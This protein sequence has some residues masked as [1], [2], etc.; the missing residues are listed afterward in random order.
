MTIHRFTPP[1]V[2]HRL[3]PPPLP[4]SPPPFTPVNLLSH[5]HRRFNRWTTISDATPLRQN[6][7]SNDKR[8]ETYTCEEKFIQSDERLRPKNR[9][10]SVPPPGNKF[11]L[12]RLH[13]M[14]DDQSDEVTVT[15][16]ELLYPVETLKQV[17]IATFTS[18]L[19][20]F[21]SYCEIPA[22]LPLS[23]ACHN[24]ERC[25]SSSPDKR[26]S[27]TY[28]DFP[29]LDVIYPQFPEL[30][31]FLFVFWYL[32]IFFWVWSVH[33]VF[34]EMTSILLTALKIDKKSPLS[35]ELQCGH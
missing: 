19:S 27:R 20:W 25:W 8:S 18:D 30:P 10:V 9:G 28:A 3:Q 14:G 22:H 23:I 35:S 16:P 12:N 32:T 2:T 5:C 31:V 1:S 24:A 7:V 26:T 13:F 17:F 11:Y 15:L 21:L 33:K 6:S 34:D 4:R 29:N